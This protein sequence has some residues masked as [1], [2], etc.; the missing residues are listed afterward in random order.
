MRILHT[1]TDDLDNPLRGGQPV[2]TFEVNCRLA[3]RHDITVLT[4]TYRGCRRRISREGVAYRRL[5]IT[6]PGLGLSPHLSFLA[7]LGV[8]AARLP[9]DLLVEEFTP[10]LGFALLP[11]WTKKPVVCVVQWFFFEAWEHRYRLPFERGMRALARLGIYR[12]FIVQTETMAQYFRALAPAARI[13][14]LG[15]GINDDA[16][17]PLDAG[18]GDGEFA[19]FLGR[20]DVHHKGLDLLIATWLELRRAGALVPLK[21]VGE[22]PGRNYL[23]REIKVHGLETAVTLLGRLEGGRKRE[24]LRTCAFVVMPSRW[25]TFGIVALE[26]MASAKPVIGFDI[27]NLNE[28]LRPE[29]SILVDGLDTAALAQAALD[30]VRDPRFRQSLGERAFLAARTRRWDD[31]AERQEA[32]YR[33]VVALE[34]T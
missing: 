29:W 17:Q 4:A 26:A 2:R 32:I 10:P 20:L 28:V 7:S 12:N 21:I 16:F 14:T 9:H 25:E 6:V 33:E 13:W 30:L 22:G 31:I 27:D 8:A 23:E 19:L 1:D 24:V 18:S 15:C 5:G 3:G 11:Y 34:P